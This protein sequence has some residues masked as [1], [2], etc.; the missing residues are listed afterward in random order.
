M[1]IERMPAGDAQ[2]ATF[3]DS[4]NMILIRALWFSVRCFLISDEGFSTDCVHNVHCGCH[5]R[6]ALALKRPPPTRGP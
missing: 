3:P 1:A 4:A 2:K 5:N 6:S